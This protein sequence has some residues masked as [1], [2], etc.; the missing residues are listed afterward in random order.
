MFSFH[1]LCMIQVTGASAEKN[2]GPHRSP[3]EGAAVTGVQMC[4]CVFVRTGAAKAYHTSAFHV[5]VHIP[6][7]ALFTVYV[8]LCLFV[9]THNDSNTL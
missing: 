9:C 3:P 7:C 4:V 1:F 8:C 5:F 2:V 6:C